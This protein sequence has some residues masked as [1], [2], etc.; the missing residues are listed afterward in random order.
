MEEGYTEYGYIGYID[1]E[2]ILFATI[3]EYYAY[4]TD[5]DE[6]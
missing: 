5:S 6:E 3:D 4:I 1:G 2:Y